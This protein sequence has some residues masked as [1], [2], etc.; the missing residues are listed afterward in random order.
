MSDLSSDGRLGAAVGESTIGPLWHAFFWAAAGF[1]FLVG[2]AAMLVP[3]SNLDARVTGILIF[4]FGVI[5]AL[6]ARDP[7]R[8][9][10]ALWAGVIGKLG[11]VGLLGSD[12]FAREVDPLTFGLIAIDLIFVIGFLAFLLMRDGEG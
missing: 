6:V 1:N 10:S 11:V 5:Y 7:R 12:G 2:L 9:G 8:Y 4:A 3:A